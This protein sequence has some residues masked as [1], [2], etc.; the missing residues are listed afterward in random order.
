MD[1]KKKYLL[2][3]LNATTYC[4]SL[5]HIREVL[6]AGDITPLP[7]SLPFQVGVINVR[8]EIIAVIDLAKLIGA[9]KTTLV[10]Q[11]T[12]VIITQAQDVV[13]GIL[14]DAILVVKFF[15]PDTIS[16]AKTPGIQEAKHTF[17]DAFA[18]DK[19][20][21]ELLGVLNLDRIVEASTIA[22]KEVKS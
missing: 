13:L 7:N 11:Q 22:R 3:S 20:K 19:E 6:V 12:C 16:K 1:D 17:V 5:G 2:F 15:T 18:Q 4:L 10:P 14:V 9:G 21:N 8:G